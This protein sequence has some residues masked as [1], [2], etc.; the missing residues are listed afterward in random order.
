M[1]AKE[2]NTWS[3]HKLAPNKRLFSWM[4]LCIL[5]SWPRDMHKKQKLLARGPPKKSRFR[6]MVNPHKMSLI[7]QTIQAL[8]TCTCTVHN[9]GSME[10]DAAI[11]PILTVH[12][13]STRAHF[14]KTDCGHFQRMHFIKTRCLECRP[15]ALV[16]ST[17]G[18]VARVPS[19][20]TRIYKT[21]LAYGTAS[22]VMAS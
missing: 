5:V 3:E 7:D 8:W 9:N 18:A 15:T 2:H 21:R 1:L 6:Q 13:L 12:R 4:D 10:K 22:A 19:D 17:K 11:S 16:L 20:D 14:T